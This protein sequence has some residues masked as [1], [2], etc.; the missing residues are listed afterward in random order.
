MN[1]EVRHEIEGLLIDP[2]VDVP[3]RVL[4]VIHHFIKVKDGLIVLYHED[5]HVP[6][7]FPEHLTCDLHA[8]AC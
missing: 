7:G 1:L 8:V 3:L 2:E 5:P 6:I 4:V